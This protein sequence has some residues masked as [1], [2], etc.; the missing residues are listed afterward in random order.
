[1]RPERRRAWIA[2]GLLVPAPTVGVLAAYVLA[3]GPVGQAVYALCKLWIL[4]LPLVWHLRVER[5]GASS[6]PLAPSARSRAL[7][8]GV[9]LGVFFA[10]VVLATNALVGERWLDPQALREVLARAGLD[11]P[12]RYLAI[13]VY[14]ALV[15]SLLEEY[16]W[17]WF[18]FQ[19][20][21]RAVGAGL[22]VPLAALCFTLHHVLVFA[23]QL[24][25]ELAA[26][27]SVAV[28][29]AGCL[30]SWLYARWRSIWPGW[31]SHVLVDVAGLWIG[32]QLLFWGSAL[33]PLRN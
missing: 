3:P 29:V 11:S 8:E 13:A 28:F 9:A 33:P 2:L 21:E 32:W 23:I 20:A 6:S 1:M 15:N 30:W 22:G 26:L 17:R 19:Q 24:G 31:V 4:A 25:P 5:G 10:A 14:I 18:A 27:G 7:L 12:G 16:V